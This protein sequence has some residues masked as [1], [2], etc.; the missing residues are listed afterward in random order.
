MGEGRPGDERETEGDQPEARDE[1]QGSQV[2]RLATDVVVK[3]R[4]LVGDGDVAGEGFEELPVVTREVAPS[5]V[6]D[7]DDADR[8]RAVANRHADGDAGAGFEEGDGRAPRVP[9]VRG[10]VELALSTIEQRQRAA[11]RVEQLAGPARGKMQELVE[12]GEG[13]QAAVH[14]AEYVQTI[15]G[16]RHRVLLP[17]H[18]AACWRDATC[19]VDSTG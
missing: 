11:F 6:D 16:G 1:L 10:E 9:A 7:V 4:L 17:L 8:A 14:L 3:L 5:G 13:R 15:R 18:H 12:V 19:A 2:G